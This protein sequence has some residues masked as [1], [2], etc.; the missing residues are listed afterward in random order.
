MYRT[1]HN[2]VWIEEEFQR[3]YVKVKKSAVDGCTNC[4]GVHF[5]IVFT[6]PKGKTINAFTRYNN[7]YFL[8]YTLLHV[9]LLLKTSFCYSKNYPTQKLKSYFKLFYKQVL[10]N[11][12][13]VRKKVNWTRI[14]KHHRRK[15]VIYFFTDYFNKAESHN[16]IYMIF[17]YSEKYWKTIKIVIKPVFRITR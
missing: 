1:C 10:R 2:N 11:L 13:V 4:W 15:L 7:T 14:F 9:L 17:N 8:L 12:V 6:S 3:L 5:S 16:Q